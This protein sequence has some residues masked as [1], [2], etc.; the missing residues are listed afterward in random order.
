MKEKCK[1]KNEQ[2]SISTNNTIQVNVQLQ[3][4]GIYAKA[5]PHSLT[6][7]SVEWHWG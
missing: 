3:V 4:S 1:S 6:S 5:V 2:Y 7:W